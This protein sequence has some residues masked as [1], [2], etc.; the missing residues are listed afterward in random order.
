MDLRVLLLV[1]LS[2]EAVLPEQTCCGVCLMLAS[3]IGTLE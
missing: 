2:I 1:L 3:T